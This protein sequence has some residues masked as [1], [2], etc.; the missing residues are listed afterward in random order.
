MLRWRRRVLWKGCH[1]MVDVLLIKD[2]LSLQ[3]GHPHLVFELGHLW[4]LWLY[5]DDQCDAR[6]RGEGDVSETKDER[7]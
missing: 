7:R 3:T 4:H 5:H 1:L 6:A 2:G